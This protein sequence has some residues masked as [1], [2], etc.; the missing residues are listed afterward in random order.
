M[1]ENL[2]EIK[3]RTNHPLIKSS[4][5]NKLKIIKK[6]FDSKDNIKQNKILKTNILDNKKIDKNDI[7]KYFIFE[8]EYRYTA[9][10]NNSKKE[11]EVNIQD[12]Q[13]LNEYKTKFIE[14]Y[15]DI[16]K[17]E[18]NKIGK[19]YNEKEKD[20]MLKD[21]LNNIYQE[22]YQSQ[23]SDDNSNEFSKTVEEI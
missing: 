2:K 18:E 14:L 10:N 12:N 22:K 9:F 23:N 13:K 19:K 3:E 8:K 16:I 7:E 20:K 1:E 21:L 17:K 6:S 11:T 15:N 5:V 4:S